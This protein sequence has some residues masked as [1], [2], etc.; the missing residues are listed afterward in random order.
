MTSQVMSDTFP[1][2]MPTPLY[3]YFSVA[4]LSLEAECSPA[5]PFKCGNIPIAF[6]KV[7]DTRAIPW[8]FFAREIFYLGL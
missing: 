8:T 4:F 3:E 1:F 2:S 5:A 6:F 7:A